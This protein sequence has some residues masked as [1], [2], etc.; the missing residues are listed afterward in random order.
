V[1]EPFFKKTIGEISPK[2]RNHKLQIGKRRN[3]GGFQSPEMRRK[4][5]LKLPDLAKFSLGQM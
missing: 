2:K 5:K 1:P 3:F 4:N